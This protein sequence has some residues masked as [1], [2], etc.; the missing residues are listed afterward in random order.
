M[1]D[2]VTK[3]EMS[4]TDKADMEKFFTD[5]EKEAETEKKKY[6]SARVPLVYREEFTA[7]NPEPEPEPVAA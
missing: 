7:R 1:A 2:P 4:E 6:I 5:L 3:V